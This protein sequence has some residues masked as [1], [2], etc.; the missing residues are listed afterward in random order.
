MS[1]QITEKINE[2]LLEDPNEYVINFYNDSKDEL[3]YSTSVKIDN[4]Y[5]IDYSRL[6]PNELRSDL[7][8]FFQLL[9]DLLEH[10]QKD[11]DVNKIKLVEDYNPERFDTYGDEVITFQVISRAPANLDTKATSRPQ[12]K[13]FFSHNLRFPENANKVVEIL[14]MPKDHE[15]QLSCWS[16]TA[17]L[18]NKRALWLENL[19]I[20]NDWVFKVK[21]AERFHWIK[22]GEDRMMLVGGQRLYERPLRY[23]VRLR[24]YHALSHP[25]I[26][27]FTFNTNIN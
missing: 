7:I 8:S 5:H 4:P 25:I 21:G 9:S 22:R 11:Q 12:R 14:S 6:L 16:K 1:N 10:A 27:G 3:L 23:F 2:K 13:P 19:L 18:A 20:N 24:D 26:S 15:I 17:S